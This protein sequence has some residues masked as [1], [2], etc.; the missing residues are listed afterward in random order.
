M[1]KKEMTG[2]C[3]V[4]LVVVCFC[5]ALMLSVTVPALTSGRDAGKRAVCL[6]N[7]KTLGAAMRLYAQDHED[8][9]PCW[10]WEFDDIHWL[11]EPW[12]DPFPP[13]PSDYQLEKAFELGYIWEYVQARAAF[14][15]PA[16]RAS[17]NPN[18]RLEYP[19]PLPY[20]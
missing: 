11:G 6:A 2:F 20:R 17:F 14:V 4:E 5:T 13:G 18:L 19:S 8:K 7:L 15:C 9:I 16:L 10:G 1:K 3:R 12:T